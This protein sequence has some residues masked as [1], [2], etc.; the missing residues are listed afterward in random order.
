M[1]IIEILASKKI[2][3]VEVFCFTVPCASGYCDVVKYLIDEH[4]LGFLS[5]D[6][7]FFFLSGM[8]G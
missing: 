6:K 4:Q 7:T 8:R 5:E 1:S 2:T 3:M